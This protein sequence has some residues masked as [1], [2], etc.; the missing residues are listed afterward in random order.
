MH[1]KPKNTARGLVMHDGKLLLMERWRDNLHY[2][3]IP[4]GGIEPGETPEQAVVRELAEETSCQVRLGRK[5]YMVKDGAYQH[6]FFLCEYLSGEPRLSSDAPEVMQDNPNNR[7]QPG[8]IDNTRLADIHMNVWEMVKPQLMRD[9]A[10][11]FSE[12]VVE[13][14]APDPA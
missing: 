10:N 3:S 8:W 5:V 12:T 6:H 14:I 4:G 11:G 1:Y 9:L 7:F 13:I 2:F